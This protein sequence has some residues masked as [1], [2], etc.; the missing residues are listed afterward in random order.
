MRL[1][2]ALA[3]LSYEE[4]GGIQVKTLAGGGERVGIPAESDSDLLQTDIDALTF[5]EIEGHGVIG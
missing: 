2:G 5:G 4:R 3:V 1:A